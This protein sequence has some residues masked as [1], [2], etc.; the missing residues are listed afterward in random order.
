MATGGGKGWAKGRRAR[1]DPRIA[2]NAEA[3]RGKTY[4][5]HRAAAGDRRRRAA[6]AS[7]EWTPTLAYAVGLLAT[8]GCQ[9]DGRHLAFPSADRELVEILLRCLGKT[10]KIA[11]I[12]TRTGGIV[13]KTQIGDVALCRWLETI[14]ITR[15]KSLTLGPLAVPDELI[16]E[17][18]RG[19]MDGDGGITNF[20]HAATKK[21][22]PNYRYERIVLGFTSA[23]RPH[24]DWLRGKLE[25]Y[26]AAPGWLIVTP[27]K[28]GRHA[29]FS[30]RYGKRDGLRLLPFIYRDTSVPW[31]ERKHRIWRSYVERHP[32][33]TRTV[34]SRSSPT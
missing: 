12:R 15:R 34:Q 19:L 22:Y 5:S 33:P 20:T 30:L 21:T 17:C 29:F 28:D 16:L 3:H 2:K 9:T 4:V 8:D 27:P 32:A 1:D 24:L 31:L 25:S 7:T 23:S 26:A 13:Y 11:E 18:A 10:N 14:G 6:P